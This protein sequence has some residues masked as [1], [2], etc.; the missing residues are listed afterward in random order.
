MTTDD[1]WQLTWETGP[2]AGESW[3][4]DSGVHVV[5]RA[6]QAEVRCDDLALE[7]FHV[8]LD[9]DGDV[10]VVR[11]LA[12]R[13]PVR[14]RPTGDD[15][16]GPWR[17]QLGHSDLL[18]RRATSSRP[19]TAAA[20]DQRVTRVPRR[21]VAWSPEPVHI[22]P[23]PHRVP[24]PTGGL[25]PALASLLATVVVALVVKQLMFVVVGA[26]GTTVAASTWVAARLKHRRACGEHRRTAAAENVRVTSQLF[27]QRAGWAAHVG[28]TVPTLH[29]AVAAIGASTAVWQRRL[30]DP[31]GLRVSLGIGCLEWQ[32]VADGSAACEQIDDLPV[33][34][35]LCA[36]ARLAINGPHAAA[37]ANAL[38]LQ[39]AALTGPADWQLVVVTTSPDQW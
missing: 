28:Q 29:A 30:G 34:I 13:L 36:G 32:P 37:V 26:V 17:V 38:V 11:Q 18:I 24:A 10:P 2:D 7:P 23:E 16:T 31:D 9:L 5:G 27:A 35:D 33:A 12:G 6:P 14:V 21:L 1:C 15:T 39:L 25:V 19:V 8:Q 3:L 20:N 4:L 22:E